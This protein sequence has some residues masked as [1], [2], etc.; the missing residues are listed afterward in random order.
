MCVF[1]NVSEF[2]N[3]QPEVEESEQN[4]VIILI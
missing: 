2:P 3:T 4:D 1:E